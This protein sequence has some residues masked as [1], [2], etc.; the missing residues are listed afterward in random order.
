MLEFL[1]ETAHRL[2][3]GLYWVNLPLSTAAALVAL[4][5]WRTRDFKDG[6]Q[7]FGSD[8][9][10]NS[11]WR[12]WASAQT[13][14]LAWGAWLLTNSVPPPD[15]KY[16]TVVQRVEVPRNQWTTYKQ[17]ME[18]CKELDYGEFTPEDRTFCDTR[19]LALTR[20]GMLVIR[21]VAKPVR[22]RIPDPYQQL[23]DKCMALY[24]KV[25]PD[26][27]SLE[28]NIHDRMSRC[29]GQALDARRSWSE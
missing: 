7:K 10:A 1:Q 17:A 9:Y 8:G 12:M 25:Y 23:Y 27:E 22:V 2:A 24:P 5:S 29:H 14:G 18:Q 26:S 6:G 3:D 16:R 28:T 21:T 19:A 4:V 20:P 11:T 13:V 15:Y